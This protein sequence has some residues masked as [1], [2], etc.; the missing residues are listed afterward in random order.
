MAEVEKGGG[1]G[2][3][4]VQSVGTPG[5]P[6]PAPAA[7]YRNI[8]G[9]KVFQASVPENWTSLSSSTAIKAVPQNGYGQLNGQTVFSH[10]VEFGL[11]KADSRDLRQATNAWLKAVAQSNPN[12]RVDGPQRDLQISQRQALGTALLNPSPLGGQERIGLY[13]TFLTSGNLFYYLTIVQEKDAQ[14]F[15][16]A[17]QRIGNSIQLTDG[18]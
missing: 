18:R 8:S 3:E 17:F 1:G 15:Q 14:T 12:L 16:D 9:G 4:T 2:G 6:V 10:G 7:Q 11:A 5:Q 13:T